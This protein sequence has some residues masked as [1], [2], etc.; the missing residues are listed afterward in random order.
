MKLEME[1]LVLSP[2]VMSLKLFPILKFHFYGYYLR[3]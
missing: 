1:V 3:L 2:V